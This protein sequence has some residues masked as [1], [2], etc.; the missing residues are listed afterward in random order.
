[1]PED[2]KQSR[3]VPQATLGRVRALVDAC[4]RGNVTRRAIAKRTRSGERHIGYALVA[5]QS[6][7]LVEHQ[8]GAISL[9]QLGHDLTRTIPNSEGEREVLLQAL[10]ESEVM[11]AI[12]P[13][14]A[15]TSPPSKQALAAKIATYAGLSHGTAQHRAAMI[16]KW[17]DKLLNPQLKMFKDGK[18]Q[19]MWRRLIIHNFRSIEGADIVLAPF[20]VV[21]GPNGSGKSNF[22]D[23]LVFARDVAMDASAAI[24][25]RGGISGVR[26]WRR[27]KPADV[28]IDI[29]ASPTRTGLDRDYS[30]HFF[31]VHSGQKGDWTFTKELIEVVVGGTRRA[32][33]D[34]QGLSATSGP[35]R[36][37]NVN[38]HA[39]AMVSARQYKDFSHTAAL[40]NVRRYRL[41]P[42]AM[43]QPQLS[44]EESRLLENG[45]NVAVAMNSIRQTGSLSRVMEPMQR[46]VP[47]LQDISVEQVGR[48][49]TLK[50]KQLQAEGAIAE[51][52]ATEMSDGALRSLGIVIAT[53]QMARDELLIIEEP[54]V[55]VHIG[56][57]H[58]LFELL[59]EASE[60]GAVLVT[61][62]SADLLDA[63]RDEEILVCDYADG[64]TRIGPLSRDQ[65]DI[66][67]E[68]LFSV[69][70]L[71]R[72]EPLRI[73]GY[74]R[75]LL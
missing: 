54:E 39:S 40:R 2:H 73:E 43:R 10:S 16:L 44:S 75:P 30:R 24:S 59:K 38:R 12:A 19:G 6:L 64:E 34:R 74:D 52:N 32:F 62:H 13:S 1:M 29:R 58:L 14:L 68:G 18:D 26:R 22:A 17:R 35:P 37:A 20:T 55:S 15:G 25:T 66:V 36:I 33:V 4:A 61:T 71:M 27:Y 63:A 67:R 53:Q 65:R 60:R 7:G 47:A 28:L 3:A 46:I 5:A 69:S 21:V 11:K 51:F 31:K 72:S 8:S 56:A 23:A 45:E 49:L 9:T 57:A 70:E 41:N 50:F 42:D 48:Y